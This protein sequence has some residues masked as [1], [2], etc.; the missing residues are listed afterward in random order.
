MATLQIRNT[1]HDFEQWKATF[2]RYDAF[3]AEHRVRSYRV[4]RD[5]GDQHRVEVALDFDSAGD[6]AAF[7][8]VLA[9]QVF[10]TPQSREI[11]VS[12]EEP[13]I[14]ETVEHRTLD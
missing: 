8:K 2:D 9:E 1:V 11:L 4:L 12:H 3:R 6:A 14:L 13:T 10:S 5:A 7:R